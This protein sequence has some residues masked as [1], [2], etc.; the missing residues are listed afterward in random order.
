M[1]GD[2]PL[3]GPRGSV[4][5]CVWVAVRRERLL[6]RTTAAAAAARKGTQNAVRI[7][8]NWFILFMWEFSEARTTSFGSL[9]IYI[10]VYVYNL[11]L[12]NYIRISND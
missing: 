4:C 5:L 8:E 10:Y 3:S 1:D 7:K 11:Y 2:S 9:Y 6:S 12:A